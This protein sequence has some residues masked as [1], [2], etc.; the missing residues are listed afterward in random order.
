MIHFELERGVFVFMYIRE[1]DDT[2]DDDDDDDDDVYL[3]CL[4]SEDVRNYVGLRLESLPGLRPQVSLRSS[5]TG[6]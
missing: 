3:Y 5:G 1:N 2:D 4:K 6:T